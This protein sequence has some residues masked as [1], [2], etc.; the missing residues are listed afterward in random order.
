MFKFSENINSTILDHQSIFK[1]LL[2]HKKI[3]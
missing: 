1:I 3:L 2:Q